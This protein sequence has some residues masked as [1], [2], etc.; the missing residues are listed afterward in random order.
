[1]WGF[2]FV[3]VFMGFLIGGGFVVKFGF[4]VRLVCMMLFVVI[5]MGLFGLVF[6]LCEWWLLY[7]VGMWIYMV[8][9]LFVEVVE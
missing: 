7:V 2:V 1:M 9:V 4:G 8:L 3:F 6:M 5:V